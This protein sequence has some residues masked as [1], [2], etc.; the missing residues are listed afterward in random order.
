[1]Y[2]RVIEGYCLTPLTRGVLSE[3]PGPGPGVVSMETRSG[4]LRSLQKQP[5]HALG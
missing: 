5:M 1:M 3:C 2:E 4:A